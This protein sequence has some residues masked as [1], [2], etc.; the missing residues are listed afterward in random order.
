MILITIKVIFYHQVR[1]ERVTFFFREMKET[2]E[3]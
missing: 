3:R 2:D 1:Q